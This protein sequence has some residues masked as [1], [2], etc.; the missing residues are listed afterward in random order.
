MSQTPHPI[1]HRWMLL[2]A[3]GLVLGATGAQAGSLD[4]PFAPSSP[5]SALYTL[6]DLYQRLE[7]GTAG[8]KRS[9][10]FSEPASGP[11][12]GTMHTLDDI[13]N[14]MPAVDAAGASAADVA[15]GKTFW[16][17]TETGWGPQTGTATSGAAPCNCTDGT[18]WNAANGGTRWCDNGNGTVTDLLGATV[19]GNEIE[20][21]CL[22]WLK[23]ASWGGRKP[24]RADSGFD[25]AHTR[26]GIL[27]SPN[28]D[29]GLSDGSVLGRWRLPTLSELKALTT[30]PQRISL[31][32]PGPFSGVRLDRYWSSTSIAN[33]PELAW[34]VQNDVV[35]A[36]VKTFGDYVWPVRGGQ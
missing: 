19:D 16:G 35:V 7:N 6:D 33:S 32:S 5:A 14:K 15:S 12:A 13:M 26:A 17:L 30:N 34:T 4:A 20:G 23:N 8:A 36:S 3:V 10:G 18:I 9:G 24:W 2:A 31:S 29:A 27:S 28:S 25:D 21:R 1:L 22:V 11:S